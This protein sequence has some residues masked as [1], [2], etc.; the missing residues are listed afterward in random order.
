VISEENAALM[1]EGVSILVATANEERIPHLVRA[2]G[3]IVDRE[4]DLMTVYIPEATGQGT[5][6]NLRAVPRISVSF[7]RPRD[8]RGLQAKGECLAIRP[9]T[10]V[11]RE[12]VRRYIEAFIEANR[13]FGLEQLLRRW[14]T[15]PA[16]AVEV[17]IEALFEQTPGK[18][19][20]A[21]VSLES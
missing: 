15:W 20:G 2:H 16:I 14:V 11:D 8:Y 6:A 17:H 18:G 1:Q 3:V 10:A 4:R 9:G 7:G 5:F 21:K 12:L 13:P 19:A